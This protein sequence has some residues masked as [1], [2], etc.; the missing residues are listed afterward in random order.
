MALLNDKILVHYSSDANKY[1]V[2]RTTL[3]SLVQGFRSAY[4]N[5]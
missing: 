4:S 5:L 1:M 3:M 2:V